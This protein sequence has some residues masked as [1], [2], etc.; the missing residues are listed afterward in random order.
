MGIDAGVVEERLPDLQHAEELVVRRDG[1]LAGWS[2]TKEGQ[3]EQQHLAAG[4]LAD[5]GR[6][7]WC[8]P[9]T[10]ASWT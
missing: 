9:R 10:S 5:T 4:E 6:A 7:A 2:L 3:V 1:R 8:V